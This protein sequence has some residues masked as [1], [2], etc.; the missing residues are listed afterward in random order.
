MLS[1]KLKGVKNL[2]DNLR[3]KTE[4]DKPIHIDQTI[5]DLNKILIYEF[6]YDYMIPKW[7]KENR[8][9]CCMNNTD[10]LVIKIENDV[11]FTK[12]ELLM[13]GKDMVYQTLKRETKKVHY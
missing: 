4:M 13:L 12:A 1:T 11:M 9:V 3:N 8:Q 7:G 2:S 5:S 10:S 6:F